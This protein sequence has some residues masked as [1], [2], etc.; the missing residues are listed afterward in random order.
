MFVAV[1]GFPQLQEDQFTPYLVALRGEPAL[2]DCRFVG[3]SEIYW[4][5]NFAKL[6]NNTR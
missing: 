6:S 3:A 1:D 4:F 5:S 2:F